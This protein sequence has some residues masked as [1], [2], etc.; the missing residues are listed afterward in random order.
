MFASIK[1]I[2]FVGIGGIGMSGIAEVLF[3]LGYRISGSDLRRSQ[4]TERLSSLGIQVH[5]GHA[6]QHVAEAD[7][8][9][10]SSG[11]QT[12]PYAAP[13]AIRGSTGMVYIVF[14]PPPELPARPIRRASTSP[15][16]SR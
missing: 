13:A 4:I 9:V 3:N 6:P 10:Y 2:H 14:S 7:V 11:L 16:A 1:R 5:Y 8:V 15:R 12:K